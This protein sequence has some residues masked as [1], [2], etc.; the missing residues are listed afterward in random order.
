M[1]KFPLALGLTFLAQPLAV[2]QAIPPPPPAFEAASVKPG[3]TQPIPPPPAGVRS[4]GTS[5]SEDP[6]RITYLN[7]TLTPVL[8]R[9]YQVKRRQINGP[10]W[11]ETQEYDIIATLPKGAP[12]EQI[13]AMLQKLLVERF[14]MAVHLENRQEKIYALII[15]KNGP[16]LT[17]SKDPDSSHRS[18]GFDTKGHVKF[19]GF[20]LA[21]LADF[22]TNTLDRSVIDMTN[23]PGRYD[24]STEMDLAALRL[25]PPPVPGEDAP[26]P[27]QS[28]FAALEELGLKLD[29]REG[30]VKHVVIDRAEKVP[31]EN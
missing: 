7:T 2:S 24:I 30:M 9:A 21:D 17:E 29:N 27:M 25:G 13:P 5:V 3:G 11:L 22:L 18:F 6:G 23:L 8:M 31:V 12:K 16:R 14:K 20:S 28:V 1:R 15:G 4:T 10:A 19:S 26:A